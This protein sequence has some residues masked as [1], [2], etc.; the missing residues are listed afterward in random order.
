MIFSLG[1]RGAFVWL[2]HDDAATGHAFANIV[3]GIADQVDCDAVSQPRAKAL[4]SHAGQVDADRVGSKALMPISLGN[5]ARE[6]RSD[7]TMDIPDFVVDRDRIAALN[8]VFACRD[9]IVVE[10][11]LKPM[12]LTFGV[13]QLFAFIKRNLM[14]KLTQIDTLRLPVIQ[15]VAHIQAIHSANHFVERA[16]AHLGHDL[17]QFLGNEEEVIDYMLGL[18]GEAL[19]QFR[20]LCGDTN[21]ACV[22]VA[23]AH[24]DAAS[25]N[26]RRGGES[27]L[28]RPQQSTDRDIAPG[29]QSTINLNGNATAQIVEQ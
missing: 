24:H 19:A 7:R 12:I 9:Q 23:L 22:Q 21:R 18:S 13:E 15:R 6:H 8:R 16:E 27:E 29:P 2:A 25:R 10:R 5:F 17:A 14:Q 11:T 28:V 1:S 4:A 3:I 20:V 26:Q